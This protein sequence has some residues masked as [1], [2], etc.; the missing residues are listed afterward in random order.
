MR[1]SWI[2]RC[3]Q[4]EVRVGYAIVSITKV[5]MIGK[6]ERLNAELRLQPIS[7]SKSAKKTKI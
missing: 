3:D 6:V 5:W 7:D 1:R 2:G 4:P